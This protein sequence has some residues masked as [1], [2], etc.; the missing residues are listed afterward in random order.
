M[1]AQVPTSIT[2]NAATAAAKANVSYDGAPRFV[3]ISGTSMS[4]ATNTAQ[5]VIQAGD[6]YYLCLQ[7]IWFMSST[8][9]GPWQTA[10]SVPQVI[11]TIPP[12]SPVYNV[13]YVTQV[14]ASNGTVQSSYTAGYMGAFIVGAAVG[15]V[16]AGGTGYYYPPY[17]YHPAYGY[18]VYHAYPTT[19]GYS[20]TYHTTTGAYG[21]SQTAY[22]AYGGSATRSASYNPYTGTSTHI[23]SASN[24]YGSA[25]AGTAYNPYTGTSA[26]TKQGSNGY[27]LGEVPR[28]SRR[29]ARA[30]TLSTTPPHRERQDRYRLLLVERPLVRAAPTGTAP[31]QVK[32]Q[33]A[34]CMPAQTEMFT[35]TRAAA[36]KRPA[37]TAAGIP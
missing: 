10:P 32:R 8:P 21:V 3:P 37:A 11:Y 30:P 15:A 13:T 2:V 25:K 7:G 24:A 35:R 16:V 5:K 17:Y 1:I 33:T 23:A 4:Y 6:L 36:G 14:S 9:Q 27:S 22:G 26:A 31:A 29:M 20:S 34:I 28:P 18:P 19:Y 12:S